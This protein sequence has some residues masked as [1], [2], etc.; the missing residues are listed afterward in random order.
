MLSKEKGKFIGRFVRYYIV[1]YDKDLVNDRLDKSVTFRFD[2]NDLLT[3]IH[4][5]IAE[6]PDLP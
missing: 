4:S 6:I 1:K 3:A 2:K 5:H